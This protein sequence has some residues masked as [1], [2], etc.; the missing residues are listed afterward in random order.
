MCGRF[1]N[2]EPIQ[3][4]ATRFRATPS[5]PG[6]VE[7]WRP[8]WNAAPTHDLPVLLEDGRG[9]RIGL[10][11]W[12]WKP[13]FLTG[14]GILVN[15]RGEEALGKRTFADA[16]RRRRCIVPATA[17]YEWQEARRQPHAFARPDRSLFGIAGLWESS[18]IDGKRVAAFLLLTVPANGVVQPVHHRMAA[19][20]DPTME[21]T[22]L[23]QHL[24]DDAIKACITPAPDTSI[25]SWPVSRALNRVSNNGPGLLERVSPD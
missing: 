7:A 13:A 15:A 12:G 9:R 20:L 19:I 1:A 14:S 11:R 18:E 21:D 4:Q 5:P 22:W 16:M 24:S 3:A 8:S 6:I 10:M 2:T 23:S 17:F 25:I